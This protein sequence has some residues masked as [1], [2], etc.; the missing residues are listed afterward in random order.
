MQENDTK[1]IDLAP[2][3]KYGAQIL[4]NFEYRDNDFVEALV[5]TDELAE[6]LDEFV[7]DGK[8][9]QRQR[10]QDSHDVGLFAVHLMF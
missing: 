6:F 9:Y 4:L 7:N 1:M 10:L 2:I 5:T 3:A 8:A